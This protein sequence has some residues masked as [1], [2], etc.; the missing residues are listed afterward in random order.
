MKSK[1]SILI[2]ILLL[3]SAQ[4]SAA[5]VE[6][7]PA[8]SEQP[9]QPQLVTNQ[10]RL[11]TTEPPV[12]ATQPSL[13]AT[14]PQPVIIQRTIVCPQC[15]CSANNVIRVL[16]CLGTPVILPVAFGAGAIHGCACGG[17]KVC[18]EVSKKANEEG[19]FISACCTCC[20][21]PCICIGGTIAGIGETAIKYVT[22]VVGF[23]KNGN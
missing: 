8:Y 15:G 21:C 16:A 12:V 11:V 10:L 4:C 3:I 1:Y 5:V 13:F 18:G 19:D 2:T 14:Q 6:A 20:C 17:L 23:I 22:G 7:P 9:P